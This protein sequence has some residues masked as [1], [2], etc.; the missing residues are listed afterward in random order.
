MAARTSQSRNRSTS[1]A[2]GLYVREQVVGKQDGLRVLQ[3]SHAGRRRVLVS[4]PHIDERGFE[5]HQPL[6]EEP[7]VRAQVEPQVGGDLI[8]A[9][10]T[11]AQLAAEGPEPFDQAAFEGGVHVLVR[12]S[13][14]KC[15]RL[16]SGV[17]VVE[18]CDHP[19]QLVVVQ[20]AR[21]VQHAGMRTRAHQVIGR[22]TPV[23]MYGRRQ[24]SERG[25]RTTVEPA[26]PQPQGGSGGRVANRTGVRHSIRRP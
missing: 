7:D 16:A 12:D 25:R 4:L 6:H 9:T 5:I 21:S 8:V 19:P 2:N 26:A 13:R 3:V 11:G 23:E 24:C 20:Q 1:R 10:S 18:S 14:D 15:A 22:K 17:E